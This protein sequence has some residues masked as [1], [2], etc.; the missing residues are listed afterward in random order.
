MRI[1][2]LHTADSNIAVFEAAARQLGLADGALHH[3]VRA[4]LLAAAE[5]AG[6]VTPE[7]AAQTAEALLRLSNGADAVILTCSTLGPVA[8]SAAD[9]SAIPISRAD[10]ALAKRAVSAGGRVV[11]L[12]AVGTT[13]PPT[14]PLFTKAAMQAPACEID[15]RLVSGAWALFKAGDLAGYHAAIAAAADQAYVEGATV[16]ALAQSSMAGAALL[17]KCGPTPLTGPETAL[18]AAVAAIRTSPQAR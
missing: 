11:V 6:M 5:Q 3:D 8:E 2:C 10:A 18:A 14:T 13:V 9:Q 16:V 17:V 1:A 12:C 15:V 4:D 7:I